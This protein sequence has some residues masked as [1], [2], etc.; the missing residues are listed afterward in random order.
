MLNPQEHL[1]IAE[2]NEQFAVVIASLPQ[3]FPEWEITVMFYSAL[4]Y[5]S[6]FLATQGHNPEN[7]HRRNDLVGNLTNAGAD[8]QNLYRL[9][10][11]IRYQRSEYTPMQADSVKEGPFRRVKDEMMALLPGRQES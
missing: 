8:Y 6:A 5:A 1:A 3:R 7:H 9:S 11:N 4:H 2:R 10:L